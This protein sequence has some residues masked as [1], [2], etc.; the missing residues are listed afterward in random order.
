MCLPGG[1]FD[2]QQ[3]LLAFPHGLTDDST[4][5]RDVLKLGS[6]RPWQQVLKDMTGE[7]NISTKA[8]LTYFKPLLNWLVTEN[9]KQGDILGWPDFSCSFEG[10]TTLTLA[11]DLGP[12]LSR[13]VSILSSSQF[14][15]WLE[16]DS[17]VG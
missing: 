11:A 1:G 12:A 2:S 13:S 6:S 4:P 17:R 8:L 9:V 10:W 5:P 15:A 7:S 3:H 16:P 14:M